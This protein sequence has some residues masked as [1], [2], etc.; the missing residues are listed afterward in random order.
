LLRS[1]V[2]SS[3]WQKGEFHTRTIETEFVPQPEMPT[4]RDAMRDWWRYGR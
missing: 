4:T 2:R 1:I 3:T